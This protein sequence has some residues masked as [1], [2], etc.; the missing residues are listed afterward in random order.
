[1]L[2]ARHIAIAAE[3][4]CLLLAD[5]RDGDLPASAAGLRCAQA[6]ETAFTQSCGNGEILIDINDLVVGCCK[7]TDI[8]LVVN[9][10]EVRV[11]CPG[12]G[13]GR[14]D[15]HLC[16]TVLDAPVVCVILDAAVDTDGR[17][18]DRVAHGRDAGDD[19]VEVCRVAGGR[20]G[21]RRIA[22]GGGECVLR[23][24]DLI[25]I[26][27][28]RPVGADAHVVRLPAV[29]GDGHGLDA[30]R[31]VV[32]CLDN[33]V[34][35]LDFQ[36]ANAVDLV[37]VDLELVAVEHYPARPDVVLPFGGRALPVAAKVDAEMVA[38]QN[39]DVVQQRVETRR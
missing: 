21:E 9:D 7:D 35:E 18:H 31:N 15:A 16:A 27:I 8:D 19:G 23:Y 24:V 10:V 2:P 36:I 37:D 3:A 17:L 39:V 22:A 6:V 34:I 14:H 5:Q 38:I 12:S 1:M 13:D 20:V 25:H 32:E 33:D 11:A 26:R 28:T 29:A 30:G 4:V